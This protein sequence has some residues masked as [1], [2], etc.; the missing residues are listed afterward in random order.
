[1]KKMITLI[2][3]FALMFALS[4]GVTQVQALSKNDEFTISVKAHFDSENRNLVQS[5]IQGTY[6]GRRTLSLANFPTA[7]GYDFAY[8]I[9]NGVLRADLSFSSQFVVSGNM[10]VEAIFVASTQR[11]VVFRDANGR[12]LDFQYVTVGGNATNPLADPEFEAPSKP[13]FVF[14]PSPW[15]KP[16]TNIQTNTVVTLQYVVDPELSQYSLTVVGGQGTGL[17]DYNEVV[18]V[19]ASSN[20]GDNKFQY[21]TEGTRIVSYEAE[22]S[23]T[24]V[25]NRTV[26]AVYDTT[27][28][29]P[30]PLITLT[31]PINIRSSHLSFIGQISVPSGFSIVEYGLLTRGQAGVLTV[32]T[33]GVVKRQST[34][35]FATTKEFLMSIPTAEAVAVRAYLVV[36]DSQGELQVVYSDDHSIASSISRVLIYGGS[37][38]ITN[39]QTSQML[40]MV[41]PLNGN[42]AVTWSVNNTNLATISASGL[43]TPVAGQTG[44]VTVTATSLADPTKST[45][46]VVQIIAAST[47]VT[48]VT[49]YSEF[50]AALN[51]TATYIVLANDIDASGQTFE[52]TRTNFAGVLDGQGYAVINLTISQTSSNGGLFKQAGGNAVIRNLNFVNPTINTNSANSG[53]LIG[54]I[55]T[56]GA[57]TIEN[58]HVSGLITNLSAGQWTHG[59]LI[60]NITAVNHVTVRNVYV[61]Y[62]FNAP[63]TGANVGGILGV[64]NSGTAFSITITNAYV[65]MKVNG[66]S[67]GGIYGAA[68]GQVQGSN[69]SNVHFSY[70][71][72][73]NTGST[74]VLGNAGLVYSQ[75]NTAG[76]NH[77]IS[78]IIVS[79]TSDL[80][81]AFG[82]NN[83]SSQVNGT[84][85]NANALVTSEIKAVSQNASLPLVYRGNVWSYNSGSNAL[86]YPV[87]LFGAIAIQ[88]QINIQN[89][90]NLYSS[91]SL[92]QSINGID[93]VW[94][95]SHPA[96][97]SST[98]VVQRSNQTTSVTLSYSFTFGSL[99][100]T[101]S[102][103][104]NVIEEYVPGTPKSIDITGSS[105]VAVNSTTQLTATV[106]PT[107]VEPLVTWSIKNNVP[108]IISVNQ[109]GVVTGLG[110]GTATVV[111]T[112]NED[113]SVIDE[114]EMTVTY[115][116]YPTVYVSNYTELVA[117]LNN[118]NNIN[119][120][121]TAN[122]TATG[123]FTQSKTT[124][125]LGVFDG[126]GYTITD[127]SILSNNN[128][129]GMFREIGGNAVFKDI[130][131]QSPRISTSH[132]NSGLLA[133]SITSSGTITISNIIVKDMITTVTSNQYTHGG[134]IGNVN[135]GGMTTTVNANGIYL[136][137]MIR[138]TSTSVST[139]N[140][141]GIVGTIFNATTINLNNA[142]IDMQVS[143][144]NTGNTGQ[145]IAGVIGQTNSSTA[146]SIQNTYIKLRNVGAAA[147][148]GNAGTVYSQMNTSNNHTVT[149][150]AV[151]TGSTVTQITNTI[152]QINGTN[153]KT[154]AAITNQYTTTMTFAVGQAFVASSSLIW[155][156]NE[157]TL[158]LTYKLPG[159]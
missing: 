119:I 152:T 144:A 22:Y 67:T 149:N 103:S 56:T 61:D 123:N 26:T 9:V 106:S 150:V 19:T 140:V 13:G 138:T 74:N 85:D 135:T 20:Q 4:F 38:Q 1:M 8:W 34:R 147:A 65:D 156:F 84:T 125:F 158:T 46:R 131:F 12:V 83:G 115:N 136:E 53:L 93:I 3:G 116:S 48:T 57:V 120:T 80:S 155:D 79:P 66:T 14:A 134:L 23:F 39:A 44:N 37:T 40:A 133:G 104:V 75:L 18:T 90:M 2:I 100:R 101:G 78:N 52:P 108:G 59:G 11:V 112:L 64:G 130:V 92:P 43:L 139:G 41:F 63:S 145:I 70:L 82:Q 107:S 54:Q 42:Q 16:L 118:T 47:T 109:S 98:G 141:G 122:I 102:Y 33:E 137:Y 27:P 29:S 143:F 73:K 77:F 89:N 6:A 127:L 30:R 128:N 68:I 110:V 32:A 114:F 76:N 24:L 86:T 111:A 17:Y 99:V 142:W 7:A 153:S 5:P 55:N 91:I 94:T 88:Q 146:S 35:L 113:H 97:L 25:A 87:D 72:I 81:R 154:N 28:A 96:L 21:W 58:I 95:S 62:T 31:G 117:A 157:E 69:I 51:G 129:P 124:R 60:G 71:R 50:A 105:S 132:V 36:E 10:T 49:N 151:M 15:D 126:Q 159:A 121:L 45:T 148:T